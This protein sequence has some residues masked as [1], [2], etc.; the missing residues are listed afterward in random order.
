MSKIVQ[1]PVAQFRDN[2]QK[3]IRFDNLH[4]GSMYRIV[5]EP[6]RGVLQSTD[7]RIYRKDLVGFFS[8]PITDQ[9]IGVVLMPYDK[10]MPVVRVKADAKFNPNTARFNTAG[11]KRQA[12]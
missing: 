3:P 12:V 7:K 1:M 4:P 2:S 11:D 10:V 6:S 5:S 8:T 9:N